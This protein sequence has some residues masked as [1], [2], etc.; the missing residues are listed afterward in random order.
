[1]ETAASA[2]STR[3][4]ELVVARVGFSAPFDWLSKGWKD[5]R[6]AGR[7]S[8]MYGALG[9][10]ISR[11]EDMQG[12]AMIPVLLILPGF[13]LA[14][15][16]LANPENWISRAASFVPFWSP[17]VMA[18][19]T[20]VSDVPLWEVAVSIALLVA[21]TYVLIMLGGR[22]YRGAILHTGSKTK[23]RAAWRGA[24]N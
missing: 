7:Y 4:Q 1:M 6:D 21:T 24:A 15:V 5:M 17:M 11:Q 22:I 12:A 14:Q 10:T 18:V 2:G 23:L 8:F 20:T 3:W 19:R 9:A 16:A 13:F